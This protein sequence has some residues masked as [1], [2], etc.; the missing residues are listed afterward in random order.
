[1]KKF[2][3]YVEAYKKL[4]KDITEKTMIKKDLCERFYSFDFAHDRL[5]LQGKKVSN[6]DIIFNY[7][8]KRVDDETGAFYYNIG[9]VE[10]VLV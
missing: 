1:M 2:K 10:V 9:S 4:N 5:Y 7:E 8:P 3:D 6:R